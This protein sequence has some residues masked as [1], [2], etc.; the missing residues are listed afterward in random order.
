MSED[1]PLGMLLCRYCIVFHCIFHCIP[2]TSPRGLHLEGGGEDDLTAVFLRYEFGGLIFGGTCFRNFTVPNVLHSD[3]EKY[4]R[5]FPLFLKF[6]D[7]LGESDKN[8]ES[9]WEKTPGGCT[10][11]IFGWRMC[12]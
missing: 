4:L 3:C 12:R 5:F 10:F 1:M 11:G 2:N 8:R 7:T 6:R 9:R